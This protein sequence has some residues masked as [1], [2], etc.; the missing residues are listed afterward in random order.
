MSFGH[1]AFVNQCHIAAP[2]AVCFDY[3][4]DLEHDRDWWPPVT[5]SQRTSGHG[6]VGTIYAQTASVGILK[7]ASHIDV[8]AHDPHQSMDFTI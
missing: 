8:T 5:S 4:T 6:G 1:V 2:Q 3:I 7:V